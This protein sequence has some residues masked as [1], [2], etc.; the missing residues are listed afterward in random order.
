[1]L[2]AMLAEFIQ[3]QPVF[4]RFL[5]LGGM[6]IHV[7]APGALQLNHVVLRHIFKSKI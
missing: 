5:V 7:L 1:M 6:I 3:F 2:F 4:E